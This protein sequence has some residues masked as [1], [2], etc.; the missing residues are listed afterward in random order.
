MRLGLRLVGG[1]GESAAQRIVAARLQAPF[2]GT[3]DLALRCALDA[4]DLKA[5]ASAD[6]LASLSG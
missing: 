3:Q 4:A 1:L 5:L 2:I 6:A